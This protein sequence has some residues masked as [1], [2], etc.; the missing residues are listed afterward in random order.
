MT[1]P[2][3]SIAVCT[4]NGE[5]YIREQLDSIIQQTYKTI[6]VV[7]VDDGSKDNTFNIVSSYAAIDARIKCF[8]NET[9]LGFNKNF[10]KAIAL[11]SADYIAISDQDD[12]WLPDK[13]QK[14]YDHI[15]DNWLV[16]S[17]STYIGNDKPRNLLSKFKLPDNYKGGLIYNYVTGHTVLINRE[18]LK[19]AFPFPE[20]GYYDWWLGFVAR[21]HN[22]ITY[23]AE[24]LTLYRIHSES[25]VQK[26]LDAGDVKAVEYQTTNRMLNA[27]SNYK[28]LKTADKVFINNLKDVYLL[29]GTGSGSLPLMKM[30][31]KYYNEL[32]PNRPAWKSLTKLIF[33]FR[34]SR[35]MK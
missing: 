26:S 17:N 6:E 31:Y 10:E 19:H 32:F 22:K 16:F 25:V 18:L 3:I 33:A 8:R 34:F 30:V 15:G 23:L 35:K 29:K 11:C 20:K 9:N 7:I 5:K 14:L 27:F 12:V 13:L 28:N 4:Y 21:Y 24:V 1:E 2:L